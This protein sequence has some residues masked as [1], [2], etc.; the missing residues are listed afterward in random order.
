MGLSEI[1][2]RNVPSQR[3]AINRSVNVPKLLHHA[4]ELQCPI[5]IGNQGCVGIISEYTRS[6]PGAAHVEREVLSVTPGGQPSLL[7]GC[8]RSTLST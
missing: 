2:A 8:V 4:H 5:N 6:A 3:V 7:S 1:G